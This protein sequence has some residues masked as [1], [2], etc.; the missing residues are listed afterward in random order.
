VIYG[1]NGLFLPEIFIPRFRSIL[2]TLVQ[3]LFF[4]WIASRILKEEKMAKSV[5]F[6]YFLATVL[7][8]ICMIS[9]TSAFS[10]EVISREI[11]RSTTLGQD[12]N[13]V[14]SMIALAAIVPTDLL[15]SKRTRHPCYKAFLGVMIPPLLAA[16]VATGSRTGMAVFMIGLSVYLLPLGWA[17]SRKS[18][19]ILAPLA[20]LALV[21]MIISDPGASS[22]WHQAYYEGDT[23]G[24][25]KI[26]SAAINMI[27][28][29]PFFGWQPIAHWFELGW[30]ITGQAEEE[31][32]V[33]NLYLHL[34]LEVGLVGAVPFLIGLWLCVRAAWKA[35][36][37]S[38]GNLSLATL[39]IILS[40]N[41]TIPFLTRKPMW[42][43]LAF[44]LA[45]TSHI[46]HRYKLKRVAAVPF[47]S[48]LPRGGA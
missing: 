24:R 11:K 13:V 9:G 38:M 10:G 39:L 47:R 3:L 12:P 16:M 45:S 1:L 25:G 22:R 7:L 31:K 20:A 2:Q 27:S 18:T 44:A 40:T 8:A 6:T 36:K 19:M 5:I 23:S 34:L 14:A 30:R 26:Y 32:D 46:P 17:K 37:G 21:Y 28:E 4:F 29:R 42:L 43:V 41:L 33:H 15:F 35:R 48:Q